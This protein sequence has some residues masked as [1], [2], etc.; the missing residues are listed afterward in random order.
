[1]L[2]RGLALGGGL[3][4]LILIVLGIKGC[5]DARANRE[6]SDYARNVTQIVEETEA[7]EQSLLRQARRPGQPLGHRLR[8]RRSTPTAA[9]WT[10]TPRGST[11]SAPPATWA[12]RRRRWS[13]STSCAPARWTKSPTRCHRARRRRAPTRRWPAIASQMQKLLATDVALRTRWCGRKSTA[14]SPTTGSTAATCRRAP[15]CRTNK[16]LEEARSP[17]RSARSAA[18]AAAKRL[19]RP[20]PRTGRRQ[21][22]R[23]RTGRRR[24]GRRS[25]AKKRVEVEVQVQNQ[26]E[27]TENGVTVSVS[28]DGNTLKGDNRRTRRP[29]KRHRV[30]PADAGAERRSDARSRSRNGARRAGHRKQRSQLHASSSNRPGLAWLT[31]RIAYLGPAGTFT[32]DALG[33]AVRGGELRAAADGDDPRR[34]PRRR[35][36]RGRPGA[37]PVRELDRGLGAADPRHARLRG[38]A[39]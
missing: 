21:R 35:A 29:A 22:Q 28:V 6:L 8:R 11:A 14:S 10:T 17:K 33:E 30:D 5:L 34:D 36:R 23:H 31:M 1:M 7:D 3:I 9:R 4:V 25:A 15:S 20:R 24:A 26:G 32:E 37:G 27:S 39:R 16:W 2:R 13:W 12:G 38:R 19:R 18:P